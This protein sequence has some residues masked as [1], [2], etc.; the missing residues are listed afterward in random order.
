[1]SSKFIEF[2]I[3]VFEEDRLYFLSLV[4][5]MDEFRG[6]FY[7]AISPV[8]DVKLDDGNVRDRYRRY[9]NSFNEWGDLCVRL[10]VL[11][12]D[13]AS[14]SVPGLTYR[15]MDRVNGHY[16]GVALRVLGQAERIKE[17]FNLYDS[18]SRIER[19]SVRGRDV[20]NDDDLPF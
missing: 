15:L 18:D 10:S 1:M 19:V 17:R 3:P 16:K 8:R 7:E 2:R 9:V 14:K 12:E 6:D 4:G 5:L 13:S 20:K 11:E